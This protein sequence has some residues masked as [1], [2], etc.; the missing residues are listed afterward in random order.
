MVC[1][2]RPT[3]FKLL[4]YSGLAFFIPTIVKGFGYDNIQ[5]QL[6]SVPPYAAG[7]AA[8]IFLA[9]VSDR[10]QLRSPF[11]AVALVIGIAGSAILLAVTH[12]IPLQYG[13]IF[14]LAMGTYSSMPIIICWYTMNLPGYWERGVGTG[15]QIGFGNIGAIVATFA[16]T[17]SDAPLYHKGYSLLLGGLGIVIASSLVYV[18][19]IWFENRKVIG[20]ESSEDRKSPASS[21]FSRKHYL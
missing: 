17:S 1:F 6:R 14:L 15:W 9:V 3:S 4:T 8:A 7:W 5:T 13:A 19:A 20:M 16:F 11:L 18:V 10:M 21:E 2:Q 12:N